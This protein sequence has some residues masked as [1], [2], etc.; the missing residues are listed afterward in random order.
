[1]KSYLLRRGWQSVLVLLGV[2]VVVYPE[3]VW[4]GRVTVADVPEIL[5]KHIVGGM[6]VERLRTDTGR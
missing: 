2:S 5:E 6:P 1:M 4:Y 3:G